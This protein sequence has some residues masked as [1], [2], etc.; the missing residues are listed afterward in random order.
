MGLRTRTGTTVNKEGTAPKQPVLQGAVPLFT[1][2][3]RDP[4]SHPG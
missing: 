4:E 1:C 3:C 2:F